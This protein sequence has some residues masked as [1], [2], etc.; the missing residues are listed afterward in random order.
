MKLL[1]QQAALD[2]WKRDSLTTAFRSLRKTERKQWS[3]KCAQDLSNELRT[4]A[5]SK[6]FKLIKPKRALKHASQAKHRLPGVRDSNG[7]WVTKGNQ[8]SLTWQRHFGDIENSVEGY[9][10]DIVAQS[11]PSGVAG[12]IDDL[13]GMPTLFDLERSIRGLNARKAPGPDQLGAEVWKADPPVMAKRC[14]ALF[15][16]SGL[17]QQWVAEFSRR[18]D[19][20][21]QKGQRR[22]IGQLQ[23]YLA[24]TSPG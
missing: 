20:A 24:G 16:K 18:F 1:D 14:F 11:K 12:T 2:L 7:Q 3:I 10:N 19:S 9:G 8:M 21:L 22:T 6:W 13:L 4:S 5:V 17:R 23:S 15:L